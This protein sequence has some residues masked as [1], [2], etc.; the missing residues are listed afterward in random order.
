MLYF[1][2]NFTLALS[3]KPGMTLQTDIQMHHPETFIGWNAKDRCED[4]RSKRLQALGRSK[5][6]TQ[7][8]V[9]MCMGS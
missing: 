6:G 5:R 9:G 8:I 1:L 3:M 4:A 7:E 2:A